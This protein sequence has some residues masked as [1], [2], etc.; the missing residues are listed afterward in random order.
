M[1]GWVRV[2]EENWCHV[3]PVEDIIAHEESKDCICGPTCEVDEEENIFLYV[4][5]SAD[6][7]EKHE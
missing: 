5:H 1:T 4:H 7:R 3:M 6:G 2:C